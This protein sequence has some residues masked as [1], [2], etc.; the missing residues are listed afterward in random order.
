M[1]VGLGIKLLICRLKEEI[2]VLINELLQMKHLP[3]EVVHTAQ[4]Q[5]RVDNIE[6]DDSVHTDCDLRT[7]WLQLSD[8]RIPPYRVPG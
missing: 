2:P 4:R 5:L 1:S 6:V 3:P 7:S 8:Y